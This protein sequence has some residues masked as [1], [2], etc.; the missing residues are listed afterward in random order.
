MRRQGYK[1]LLRR[2]AAVPGRECCCGGRCTRW[3][4]TRTTRRN[5]AHYS[6]PCRNPTWRA[7]YGPLQLAAGVTV[8]A[9]FLRGARIGSGSVTME[10]CTST[11]WRIYVAGGVSLVMEDC[12][13]FGS[14]SIG[15]YCGGK[16]EATRCIFENNTAAR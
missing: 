14:D 10:K 15:A 7:G 13:V 11:G 1:K 8:S 16:V 3:R 9:S 2:F 6:G 4:A 12:R 5:A